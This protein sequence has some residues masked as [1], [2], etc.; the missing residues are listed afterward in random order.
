LLPFAVIV[1]A[2]LACNFTA[3]H[4]IFDSLYGPKVIDVMMR[5][6]GMWLKS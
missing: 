5:K 3:D 6:P 2:A 1:D 4:T